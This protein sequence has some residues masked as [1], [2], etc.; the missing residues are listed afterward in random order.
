MMDSST[1]TPFSRRHTEM[2]VA[3]VDG[4]QGPGN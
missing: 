4:S 3:T 2:R 1:V